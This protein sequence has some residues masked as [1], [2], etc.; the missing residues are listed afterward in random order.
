[1]GYAK[2]DGEEAA[3][4]RAR[5]NVIFEMGMLAAVFPLERIAI[6]QKKGVEIPSDIH[7]VYYLSFNE[8]VKEIMPKLSKRLGEAGFTIDPEKLAYASS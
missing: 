5:Q 3:Q 8:Y 2:S 6:L 7:G 4:P 1:M